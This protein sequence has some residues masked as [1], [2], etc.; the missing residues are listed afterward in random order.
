MEQPKNFQTPKPMLAR[1]QVAHLGKITFNLQFLALAIMLASIVTFILPAIYYLMLICIAML[2]LFIAF[3]N[4]AYTKLWSGGEHLLTVA[5]FLTKSWKYTIP[6]LL[7]L[8]VTTIIC[9]IFDKNQKHVARITFSAIFALCSL[10]YLIAKLINT[11]V[12]A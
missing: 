7:A 12:I 5:D 1:M 11:G 10:I 8:S 2:T 3:A 6:I 9:L 4:P